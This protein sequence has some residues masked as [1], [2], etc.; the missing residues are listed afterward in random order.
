M[1]Q[2]ASERDSAKKE[3]IILNKRQVID[4][5]LEKLN[6]YIS[7][8]VQKLE[9]I[10]YTPDHILYIERAGLFVAHKISGHFNCPMSGVRSGRSGGS[11][12]SKIKPVLRYLPRSV[13]HLLRRLE[14]KLNIHEINSERNV[15]FQGELPSIGKKILIVDDAVDTGN[16]MKA[17]I[18]ILIQNGHAPG[19]L[20]TAVLTTTEAAPFLKPDVSLFHQ[21]ILA[22][23]WSYDSREYKASWELYKTLSKSPRVYTNG[24]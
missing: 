20:K 22:F 7:D 11:L 19:C 16:S 12:K 1:L 5:T 9:E 8:L 13:T 24:K 21:D 17:V 14:I 6:G 4:V 10:D 18:G 23:P 2:T 3:R 15:S